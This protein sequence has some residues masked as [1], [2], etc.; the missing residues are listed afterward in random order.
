MAACHLVAL[1]TDSSK[2]AQSEYFPII[3]QANVA[4]EERQREVADF[5]SRL[6]SIL[7][8]KIHEKKTQKLVFKTSLKCARALGI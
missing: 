7:I 4:E 6:R 2:L 3:F 8:E 1:R 5:P